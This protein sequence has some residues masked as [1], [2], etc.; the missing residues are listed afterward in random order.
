[1]QRIWNERT[2]RETEPLLVGWLGFEEALRIAGIPGKPGLEDGGVAS[3]WLVEPTRTMPEHHRPASGGPGAGASWQPSL[4]EEEFR[5]GVASLLESIAAGKVYQVN[6]TRRFT[7]TPWHGGLGELLDL[8][9]MGGAPPYL[10]WMSLA[11]LELVCAS[12]EL[13]LRRRGDLLET[14]PIKG[15]RPRGSGREEDQLEA[16]KLDADPSELAPRHSRGA[17]APGMRKTPIPR[18]AADRR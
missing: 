16:L 2:V 10:A 18:G 6:L 13:L 7:I 17:G 4:G 5:A 15:T 9:R 1:M 11:G 3:A 8:A 14:H 12:M